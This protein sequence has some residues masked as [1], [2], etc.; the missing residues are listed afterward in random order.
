MA[1]LLLMVAGACAVWAQDFTKID[2][3][4]FYDALQFR[5]INKGWDNCETP[6]F[7]IP[8]YLKDSTRTSAIL[9]ARVSAFVRIPSV[10]Q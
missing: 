3:L 1:C 2:T 4:Q 10:W 7:R 5:M 9:P 6:Y 8:A